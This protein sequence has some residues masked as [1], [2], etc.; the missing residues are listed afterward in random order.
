MAIKNALLGGVDNVNG[1]VIDAVDV[2]DT[3]DAIINSKAPIGSVIAWLKS[4]TNTPALP[5]WWVECNGQTL[6]D[7]DS[8]YNGQVI[9]DLNGGTHKMLRGANASGGTGGSDTKNLSHTHTTFLNRFAT[10]DNGGAYAS[11]VPTITSS[12]G[13]SQTQD[14]LPAYYAVVWIMKVK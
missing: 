13:G 5:D 2:N 12:S 11:T 9:P 1:E 3:N 6:S 8:P 4:Y 14:I 10:P 7:A